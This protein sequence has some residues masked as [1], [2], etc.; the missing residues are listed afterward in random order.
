MP[1]PRRLLAAVTALGLLAAPAAAQEPPARVVSMNLCTDQL[2]LLLA[3][4]GQLVSVSDWAARPAASNM[5]EEA[6][7]LRL[8][9]GSAEEIFLMAPDLVLAGSFTNRASV[10]MLRRLGLRVAVVPPARSMAETVARI[11]EVGGLLGRE[12]AAERLVAGFEAA[13]AGQAARAA[14]LRREPGA[15]HYPNGYTSGAD[16]L[17]SEVMDRAGLENAAA[18]LGLSGA[19]RLGLER[20]VMLEPFLVRTAPISGARSGRAYETADH[21]ALAE[22]ARR[23][24]GARF[25]ERLQVCGTPFLAEAVAALVDARTAGA[26]AAE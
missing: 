7:A 3:A 6:R 21:P 8:N 4:P 16:T 17:A 24:G 11:R 25:A 19:A 18:A 22:L 9:S 26:A 5:A 23:V 1:S 13:L 14:R 12:A 2:A 10:D 20:L 15:Y